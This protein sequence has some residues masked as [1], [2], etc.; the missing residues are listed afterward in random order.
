MFVVEFLVCGERLGSRPEALERRWFG[1]YLGGFWEAMV[2]WSD[3]NCR[4]EGVGFQVWCSGC[5]WE[6]SGGF[7]GWNG[8]EMLEEEGQ[9]LGEI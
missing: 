9:V 8:W 6:I 2:D 3:G 4:R 1:D 5:F 7:V